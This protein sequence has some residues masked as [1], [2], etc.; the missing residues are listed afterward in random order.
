MRTF[1]IIFFTAVCMVS[2]NQSIKQEQF[3]ELSINESLWTFIS[4]M[5]SVA[6]YAEIKFNNNNTLS[7]NT[8]TDGHVGPF[9]FSIND[10]VLTFNHFEF[11]IVIKTN[12]F[13]KLKN[14][15]NIYFLYKIPF[16]ESDHQK[17][18]IDPFF[19][20]RCYFLVNL[21]YIST[22]S[23]ISYLSNFAIIKEGAIL[24]EMITKHDER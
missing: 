17:N 6:K 11:K 7:I 4:D 13:I 9:T 21:N 3:E 24:E 19:I 5:H 14:K 16:N 8:D 18:Q 10:S 20:R 23:A 1:I 15:K 22:D 2:C 12:D